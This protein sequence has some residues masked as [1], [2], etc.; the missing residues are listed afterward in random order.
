MKPAVFD[1]YR[2]N[3]V[4]DAVSALAESPSAKVLAGGQ[5]LIPAMNFRLSTPSMLVDIGHLSELEAI[6]VTTD[7]VTVGAAVSQYDVESSASVAATVPALRAALRWIGHRQIRNRGTVCGSLAHADPAA[8]LP[9]LA[10]NMGAEVTVRGTE[11]SR[12]VAATDFFLGPFWTDLQPGEI[13]TQVRFPAPAAGVVTRVD[14]IARRAGDFAIVGVVGSA[15]AGDGTVSGAAF[16]GFG[17]GG[18]P[19]RLSATEAALEGCSTVDE[20]A[21]RELYEAAYADAGDPLE[22]VHATVEY[23]RE[24]LAAMVVNMSA[25]FVDGL[26]EEGG[27]S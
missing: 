27:R 6:D 4:A 8:E 26:S 16:T 22:D 25:S 1:Y 11:G 15:A 18:T 23:R 5:S 17:I 19:V 3:S 20:P 12:T 2:P 13:I 10:I 7:A 24:A 14:E 21:R 9:A